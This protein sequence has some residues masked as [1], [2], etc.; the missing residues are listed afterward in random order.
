VRLLYAWYLSDDYGNFLVDDSSIYLSGANGILQIGDYVYFDG[1]GYGVPILD[2]MPLY[3]YFL[4]SILYFFKSSFI[5]VVTVQ[6]FFDAGICVLLVLMLVQ[7]GNKHAIIVGWV[8]VFWLNLIIHSNFILTDS[9]FVFLMTAVLIC[10]SLFLKDGKIRWIFGAGLFCG[11]GILSRPIAQFMPIAM[12]VMIPIVM[13]KYNH[14]WKKIIIA[15]AL[16]AVTIFA[17]LGP[18]LYRNITDYN[19]YL[20]TDQGGGHALLWILPALQATETGISHSDASDRLNA[21]FK[22]K[23]SKDNILPEDLNSLE[24]SS[25]MAEMAKEKLTEMSI[26]TWL[27]AYSY[28][29]VINMLSPSVMLIPEVR[30]IK[31]G[32]FIDI[33]ATS[34]IDRIQIYVNKQP[35]TYLLIMGL[36]A[37]SSVIAV[38]LQIFGLIILIRKNYIIALFSVLYCLYFLLLNG[39]VGSAKYRLPLEP[40]LIILFALPL[41]PIYKYLKTRWIQTKIK[42]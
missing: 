42:S 6:A 32:S 7:L 36:G 34:L 15:I 35:N 26:A 19:S 9:I 41:E 23:L 3:F 2:R 17:I 8:S 30:N 21:K 13:I 1:E 29:F 18:I 25:L 14:G 39:P 40:V 22:E 31:Q 24:Q 27:K 10:S 12:A 11:L 38:I 33:E 28:G 5:A 37:A 20:L 16:F 4:A